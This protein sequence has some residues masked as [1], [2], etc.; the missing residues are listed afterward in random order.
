MYIYTNMYLYNEHD[1]HAI[2]IRCVVLALVP[3][4][5]ELL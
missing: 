4:Q 5:W 1:G 2:F 3:I